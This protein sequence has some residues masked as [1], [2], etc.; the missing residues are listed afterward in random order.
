MSWEAV[1][2][3]LTR[4]GALIGLRPASASVLSPGQ[5][6]RPGWDGSARVTNFRADVV[7]LPILLLAGFAWWTGRN[8]HEASNERARRIVSALA[9]HM[10]RVLDVQETMLK[11][12]LAR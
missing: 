4:V 3:A 7:L 1:T 11:S 6:A 12:A 8:V 9:D 10:H 2:A 5:R